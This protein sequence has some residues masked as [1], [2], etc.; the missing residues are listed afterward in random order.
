MKK[1]GFTLIE[2]LGVIIL[3]GVLSVI[4]VPVVRDSIKQSKIKSLDKQKSVI[5]ESAKNWVA[6]NLDELEE[7][8]LTVNIDT[9]KQTGFLE[10]K[11]IINPVNKEEMTGCVEITYEEG[12][13]QYKYEYLDECPELQ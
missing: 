5:V 8:Y 12:F 10:N 9:L 4:V 13:N 3:L 7:D 2:V 11:E 6:D 1:N